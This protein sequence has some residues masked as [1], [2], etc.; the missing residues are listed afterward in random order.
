MIECRRPLAEGSCRNIVIHRR[1]GERPYKI[2]VIVDTDGDRGMSKCRKISFR[3]LSRRDMKVILIDDSMRANDNDGIGTELCRCT[4]D[5]TI[6]GDGVCNLLLAS[7]ADRGKN[8]RR[9]W[10][11]ISSK[12]RHK[13]HTPIQRMMDFILSAN[14]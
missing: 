10:Y 6:G 8:E 3:M 5:L 11:S 14:P 2:L 9:M 13:I 7:R 1:R 4:H 12:N